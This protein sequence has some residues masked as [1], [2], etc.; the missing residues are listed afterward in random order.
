VGEADFSLPEKGTQG[1]FK[2]GFTA[3][4]IFSDS[5]GRTVIIKGQAAS[6][7]F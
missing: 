7:G 1:L 4:K 6:A 5:I 2:G 3:A